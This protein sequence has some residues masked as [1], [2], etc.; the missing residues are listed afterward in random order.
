MFEKIAY[1][2]AGQPGAGAGEST[3]PIHFF[4]MMSL[5]MVV[6]YF[7]MI[8][9]QQK[10]QQELQ[11]LVTDLKKGDKVVTIGGVI[12]TIASIQNDYVVLKVGEG[13]TKMEVLKSAISGPRS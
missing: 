5:V 10:K 11:K 6:F 3:S 7:L 1:A 8:R 13:D 4:I 2:A 12:G 9:P